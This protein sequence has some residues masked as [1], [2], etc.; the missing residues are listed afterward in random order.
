MPLYDFECLEKDCV[1]K[2]IPVTLLCDYSQK[3]N[4]FC[5]VCGEPLYPKVTVS[6][7]KING[8][9]STNNWGLGKR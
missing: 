9:S 3:T 8:D 7:F 2:N 6:S 5:N 1:S 4:Q